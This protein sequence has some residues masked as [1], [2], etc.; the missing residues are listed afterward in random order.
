LND[1]NLFIYGIEIGADDEAA[2]DNGDGDGTG[3]NYDCPLH[4]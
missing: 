1:E 2:E 4:L 3:V